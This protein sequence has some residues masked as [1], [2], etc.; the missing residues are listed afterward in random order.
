MDFLKGVHGRAHTENLK[1]IKK[2]G[3]AKFLKG[4]KHWYCE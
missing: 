1:A 2:G 4:K 3:V